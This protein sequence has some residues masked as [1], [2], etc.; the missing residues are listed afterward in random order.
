MTNLI[1]WPN[2]CWHC[3]FSPPQLSVRN[4]RLVLNERL[5]GH[6]DEDEVA[7]HSGAACVPYVSC[8]CLS[9]AFTAVTSN[10]ICTVQNVVLF[11]FS[12]NVSLSS[13]VCI[14]LNRYP[15]SFLI[16]SSLL[17][18]IEGAED[19]KCEIRLGWLTYCT[20]SDCLW[21]MLVIAKRLQS[22]NPETFSGYFFCT[23]NI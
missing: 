11:H 3:I 1:I 22:A 10:R 5:T 2:I 4:V 17:S 21:P 8:S 9:A 15:Y 6:E 16:N 14:A 13:N 20:T 19:W 23:S 7:P 12:V 18:G